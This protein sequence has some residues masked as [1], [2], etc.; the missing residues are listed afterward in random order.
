MPGRGRPWALH[1][2]STSPTTGPSAQASRSSATARRADRRRPT[3]TMAGGTSTSTTYAALGATDVAQAAALADRDQLDGV[4]RPDLGAVGVD[5]PAGVQRHRG[6]P[7]TDAAAGGRDEAHV[8]AV[9]LGR[10]AQAERAGTRPHLGLGQLA[11]REPHA[12]Q[13]AP[14]RACG[15]RRSGPWPRRRRGRRGGVPSA[16]L[17]DPGVVAGGHGVEAERAGPVGAAGRT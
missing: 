2:T 6:R 4:D 7:G 3:V 14:G 5:H 1:C 12:G 9:G 11:D 8:L 10:G 16:P 15:A 13:R 17:D